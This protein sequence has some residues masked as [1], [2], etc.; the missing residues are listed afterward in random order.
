MSTQ[1]GLLEKISLIT[2]ELAIFKERGVLAV[3]RI[4]KIT[5]EPDMLSFR[6]KPQ[7]GRHLGLESLKAFTASSCFEFLSHSHGRYSSSIVNWVLETDP[8]KV[9]H[10]RHLIQGKASVDTILSAMRKQQP[11]YD[12]DTAKVVAG[13]LRLKSQIKNGKLLSANDPEFKGQSWGGA[14]VM[15]ISDDEATRKQ[16]AHFDGVMVVS[17][18]AVL[19]GELFRKIRRVTATS[20]MYN[21]LSKLEFW[22]VLAAAANAGRQGNHGASLDDVCNR[23]IMRAIDYVTQERGKH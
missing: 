10:L 21:Y 11:A 15:V 18:Y 20:P 3:V 8:L 19:I 23:V 2:G 12:A 1:L 14:G 13:L 6:L 5:L 17:E 16:Y 4:E 22:P 7:P 9:I